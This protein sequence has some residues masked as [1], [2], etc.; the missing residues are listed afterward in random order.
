[1]DRKKLKM[2]IRE[3]D[4][5]KCLEE[6]LHKPTLKW[7]RE[8]KFKIQ[9]D[10]CYNNSTNSDFLAKARTNTLHL[11]EYFARRNKDHDKT[12]KMCDLADEDLEHFLVICPALETKKDREIMEEWQSN[13]KKQTVDILFNEKRFYK[14]G[15]MIRTLWLH[16]KDLLRPP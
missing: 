2:K 1:M 15:G 13:T 16:R 12:C 5:Q 11:T 14:T 8:G 9:Y 4:N 7:Y 3:W 6:V 10:L